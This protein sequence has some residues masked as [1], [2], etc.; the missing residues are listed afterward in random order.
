MGSFVC[1]EKAIITPTPL[2]ATPY[3]ISS[4]KAAGLADDSGVCGSVIIISLKAGWNLPKLQLPH[5][6]H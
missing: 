4:D 2:I 5:D 1:G 6:T 3:T